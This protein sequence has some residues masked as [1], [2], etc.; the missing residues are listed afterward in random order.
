MF[1]WILNTHLPMQAGKKLT[2]GQLIYKILTKATRW[3]KIKSNLL[4]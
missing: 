2:E 1:D 4:V 3:R